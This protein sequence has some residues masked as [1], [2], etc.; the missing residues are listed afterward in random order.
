MKA[1][2][3]ERGLALV[4]LA[5]AVL[6]L[7]SGG[8]GAAPGTIDVVVAR[9][10]LPAGS[11]IRA[12]ELRL[13]SISS[14]DRSAGMSLRRAELVGRTVEVS[15]AAGDYV[16]RSGLSGAA[17]PV[18]LRAGDRAVPLSL[19]A[20]SAPPLALLRAGAEVDVVAEHDADGSA[21]AHGELL[22]HRLTLLTSA[23]A[24]DGELVVTVRAPLAVALQLAT[25]Q[26]QERRLQLLAL[27][28]V[29][30]G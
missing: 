19:D 16:L 27:P 6:G 24:T 28:E 1:L 3:R 21:P 7:A 20:T 30:D 15:L 26:A 22:A 25:A 10:A 18:P 5:L 12:G 17:H 2:L 4:A 14:S 9:R 11:V 8:G 13:R 29:N 23:R